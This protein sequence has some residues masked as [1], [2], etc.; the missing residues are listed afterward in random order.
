MR[1]STR[2]R[3]GTRAMLD[4]ALRYGRGSVLVKDISRRQNI[5]GRYLEHLLIVL[6][7]AGMVRSSRGAN[8]GFTLA[9]PPS[10]IRLSEIVRAMEGPV[11][12]VDCVTAPDAYPRVGF[13][14]VHDVWDEVG[15]AIN[16]VLESI[17]LQDL[18]E[19]QA[20]KQKASCFSDSD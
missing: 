14:A 11:A 6:K 10:E 13:C 5:S 4:L 19:R 2:G 20:G 1:I 17:T 12:P 9:R 18:A 16:N 7:S 8:G 3:Y 15:R